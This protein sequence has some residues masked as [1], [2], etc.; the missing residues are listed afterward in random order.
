[1]LKTKN[2]Y[3]KVNKKKYK[4]MHDEQNGKCAICFLPET[5]K[6]N[7]EKIKNLAIDHCHKTGVIRG[8]LCQK[9]NIGLGAFLDNPDLL[10]KAIIYLK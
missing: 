10:K 3:I 7:N 4:K 5:S 2:G 8:L 1:M 6:S 9:C